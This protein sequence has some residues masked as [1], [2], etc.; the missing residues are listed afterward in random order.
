MKL[1]QLNS[2]IPYK[3]G[4]MSIQ[5]SEHHYCYPKDDKGPYTQVE[6]AVFDKDGKRTRVADL[7]DYADDKD[8]NEPVYG[9]VP[10]GTVIDLLKKDGYTDENIHGIFRRL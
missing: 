5:A 1:K 10:Y 2:A 8:S 7:K 9:Y 4:E 3:D 6:V